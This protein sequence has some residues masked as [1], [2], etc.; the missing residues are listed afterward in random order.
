MGTDAET[1]GEARGRTR[2]TLLKGKGI[3]GARGVENTR[4]A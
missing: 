3:V 4:R 1:H 2:E